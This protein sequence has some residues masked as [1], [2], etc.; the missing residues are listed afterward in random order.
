LPSNEVKVLSVDTE[1]VG[2]NPKK[3][4]PVGKAKIWCMTAAWHEGRRIRTAFVKPEDLER[5]RGL[6]ESP[7]VLKVGFSIWTYDYHVFMNHGIRLVN[8]ED[9]VDM[10]R[11]YNSSNLF[12][13]S[14]NDWCDRMGL[15]QE[16]FGDLMTVRSTKMG[17]QKERVKQGKWPVYYA[18]GQVGRVMY[19]KLSIQ[20]LWEN[21]PERRV[22]IKQYALQDAVAGLLVHPFLKQKL[23][24]TPR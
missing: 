4:S 5:W 23:V 13:H 15:E 3:E 22:R 12:G 8:V 20:E 7:L 1:T 16:K 14:K 10:S 21:H 17:H 2:C 11:W 6:L 18:P 19:K 9:I 24:E